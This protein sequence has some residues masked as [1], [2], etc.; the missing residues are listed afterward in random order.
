MANHTSNST[1]SPQQ[2][3]IQHLERLGNEVLRLNRLKGDAEYELDKACYIAR[4]YPHLAQSRPFI[5]H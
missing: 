3:Q 4:Y 1:Q 2:E 5:I